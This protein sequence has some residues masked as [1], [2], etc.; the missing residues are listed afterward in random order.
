MKRMKRMRIKKC[1]KKTWIG[2][3][4]VKSKNP[5]N[6]PDFGLGKG[7]LVVE[8]IVFKDK[9]GLG[10][11]HPVFEKEL[12]KHGKEIIE[13]NFEVKWEEKVDKKK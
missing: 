13:S 3:V 1:K 9:F 11:D 2:K 10:F 8:E 4:V 7:V 6:V 12:I 5:D